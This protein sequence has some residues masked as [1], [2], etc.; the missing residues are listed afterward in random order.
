[1]KRSWI[2]LVLLLALLA[3][4]I[5]VTVGMVRIHEPIERHLTQAARYAQQEDW[6]NAIRFFQMGKQR[7]ETWS[8]FRA[9]F[10]D[11]NPMEEI[12][13]GLRLLESYCGARENAAFAAESSRLARQIAAMGEAH[14]F[15]WWN[16]L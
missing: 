14:E 12:D 4:S 13:A 15:V 7:W 6:D 8:H 5:L 1:M 10:A 16:V 2:G 11:H 3:I 9:C